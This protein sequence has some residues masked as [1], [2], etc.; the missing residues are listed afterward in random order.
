M[1]KRE[2]AKLMEVKKKK[3]DPTAVKNAIGAVFLNRK[4]WFSP[5]KLFGKPQH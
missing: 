4:S 3:R 5:P 2:R 1:G